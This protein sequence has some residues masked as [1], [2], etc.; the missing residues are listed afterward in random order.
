MTTMLWSRLNQPAEVV[1]SLAIM[2]MAG[3][4]LTRITKALRLP[5]VTGYIIAGVVIGPDLLAL[6]PMEIINRM[7]FVT[8][9]ALAFIA[10]GVGKYFRKDILLQN[11]MQS[12]IITLFEALIAAAAIT[13]A[14][15]VVFGLPVSFALLLGAIGSATAPA[16]TLMTIRQYR[17]KGKLVNIVFQVVA[18]DDA[19]AL[20]AFSV[21]AAVVV[22][23]EGGSAFGTY[24]I[25][26]PM[27][28]NII[29]LAVGLLLGLAL[30][31]FTGAER[32]TGHRLVL[33]TAFLLLQTGLCDAVDVSPLL[34]C[35]A[36]GTAFTNAG[37]YKKV[38][39]QV[40]RFTPGIYLLFFVLA[41]MR[42]DL[43]ALAGAGV[44][45][46][47]YFIVRIAGKYAGAWLGC[48]ATNTEAP[49]RK[50]LG[51][52]LVPQAGVSIGLAQ[53]GQRLLPPVQGALLST[54]ILSSGFLY[55][56]VGPPC[57]KLALRLAGSYGQEKNKNT[58]DRQT[59][60]S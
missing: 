54:I 34:G 14:M 33:V 1:L 27:A 2:L 48:R 36:T 51:L 30:A 21:C 8:D 37:G 49:V 42:L 50:Y 46:V 23:L 4:L 12:I 26:M 59:N 31:R 22:G 5:N 6:L 45:G 20:I 24:E 13:T 39:K 56:M 47:I 19:V 58:S 60:I 40:N 35:M 57:A 41:G 52:T 16:S 28:A 25:V 55:E 53:L 7:D 32:S 44:V 17:A 11:G 15:I 9:V 29:M 18:L 43:Q 3:F 38:F 10:F